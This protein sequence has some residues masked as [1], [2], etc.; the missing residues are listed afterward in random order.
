[1]RNP[2]ERALGPPSDGKAGC[3]GPRNLDASR[4]RTVELLRHC[5]TAANSCEYRAFQAVSIASRIE[6]LSGI[7]GQEQCC[8][9]T[10]CC[11]AVPGKARHPMSNNRHPIEE[12]KL[13]AYLDGELPKD[14]VSQTWAHL[15]VCSQCQTLTADFRSVS[16]ELLAWEIDSPEVG[17]SSAI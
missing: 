6:E 16:Q 12:E 13:M 3:I 2:R 5:R 1:M 4:I 7:A 11:S 15:E 8:P 10:Q 14:Q 17:I 9:A